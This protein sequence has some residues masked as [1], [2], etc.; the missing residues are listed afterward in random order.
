MHLGAFPTLRQSSMETLEQRLLFEGMNSALLSKLVSK[1]VVR[2]G[3]EIL[4][5][6]GLQ[7]L[8]ISLSLQSLMM[9]ILGGSFRVSICQLLGFSVVAF[10]QLS[11]DR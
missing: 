4:Q 7:R 2:I 3:G 11:D 1:A 6:L 9:P 8:L 10:F 5:T